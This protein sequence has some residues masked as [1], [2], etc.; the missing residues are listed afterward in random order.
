[1]RGLI[2]AVVRLRRV[3]RGLGCGALDWRKHWEI[4]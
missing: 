1:M 3:K 2:A 4:D